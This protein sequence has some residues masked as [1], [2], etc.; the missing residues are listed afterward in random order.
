MRLDS[1]LTKFRKL[2]LN[3]TEMVGLLQRAEESRGI[4]AWQKK[5]IV[6]M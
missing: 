3:C 1:A 4:M 5:V 6:M 2:M